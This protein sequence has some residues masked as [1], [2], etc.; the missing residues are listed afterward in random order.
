MTT[1]TKTRCLKIGRSLVGGEFISRNTGNVIVTDNGDCHGGRRRQSLTDLEDCIALWGG[2]KG[3]MTTTKTTTT[4]MTLMPPPAKY[5]LNT[6]F[7]V[8]NNGMEDGEGDNNIDGN[9]GILVEVNN[10]PSSLSS[11]PSPSSSSS[12]SSSSYPYPS[13][14]PSSSSS[15]RFCSIEAA[16]LLLRSSLR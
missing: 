14:S 16:I 4:T 9:N 5:N 10:V 13:P 11:S 7:S 3:M 2:V 6:S 8:S 15:F 12:S 1:T